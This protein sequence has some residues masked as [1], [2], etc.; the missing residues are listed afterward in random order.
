MKERI[1]A[2]DAMGDVTRFM[3]IMLL[4][5]LIAYQRSQT[6]EFAAMIFTDCR[7]RI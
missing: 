3:E 2:L 5:T 7:Q 6:N 4:T 1:V